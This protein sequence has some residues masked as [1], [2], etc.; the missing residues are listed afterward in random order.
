VS[1]SRRGAPAEC[2]KRIAK[3]SGVLAV[4]GERN[5]MSVELLTIGTELL[6]GQIVDTNA[7]WMAQ[8][9]A[10]PLTALP[11]MKGMPVLRSRHK[12]PFSSTPP[13]ALTSILPRL[14]S[15]TMYR[16]NASGVL[17]TAVKPR[18]VR[19]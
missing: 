8:R 1:V 9:L 6:L 15:S 19:F 12:P 18:A 7:S 17:P 13:D 16:V 10:Q 3:S 4:G 5:L 11:G 14:V 2:E